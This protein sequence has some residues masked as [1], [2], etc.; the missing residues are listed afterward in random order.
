MTYNPTILQERRE[1]ARSTYLA[2][3]DES[4]RKIDCLCAH[5]QKPLEQQEKDWLTNA[6]D[7]L[8]TSQDNKEL[9]ALAG[10]AHNLVGQL[11]SDLHKSGLTY[12]VIGE[13]AGLSV[14]RI[15]QYGMRYERVLRFAHLT[16]NRDLPWKKS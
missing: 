6:R 11:V 7:R 5:Q 12:K 13:V 2:R 4:L 8:L 10:A 9:R 15:R 14:E 1:S 16:N 3:F